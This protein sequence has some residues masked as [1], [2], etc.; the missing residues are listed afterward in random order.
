MP[1]S[2]QLAL[3]FAV[4]VVILGL[5][6]S[7]LRR[8][9]R[10]QHEAKLRLRRVMDTVP[11]LIFAR[12]PA[13]RILLANRTFAAIFGK[14]PK[15]IIGKRHQDLNPSPELHDILLDDLEVMREGRTVQRFAR[16][17]PDPQGRMHYYHTVKVPF[18]YSN[19]HPKGVLCVSMDVT[20]QTEQAE[21]QRKLALAVAQSSEAIFLTDAHGQITYANPAMCALSGY[22]E[23]ELLHQRAHFFREDQEQSEQFRYIRNILEHGQSWQGVIEHH[24]RNGLVYEAW[25]TISPVR[26]DRELL[27]GYVCIQRDVTREKALERQVRQME[28]LESIGILTGGI[29]H[30]FNNILLSILGYAEL[31]R[32]EDEPDTERIK[33]SREITIAASRARDLVAQLLDFSG[34]AERDLTALFVNTLIEEAA[35]L[36]RAILPQTISLTLQPQ[37]TGCIR[38]NAGQILRVLTNL[39]TNA[40]QAMQN[41]GSLTIASAD[42]TIP[43]EQAGEWVEIMVQ[44]TG[45]GIAKDIQDKIFDPFFTTKPLGQ[46]TGLGLSVVHGIVTA[47]DGQLN[48]ESSAHSGTIFRMLFP[49]IKPD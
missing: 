24:R 40:I 22:E 19:D 14:T 25:T 17:L 3:Y 43:G 44:D 2:Q 38:G 13:G 26:D 6:L 49:A 16:A 4:I 20:E 23:A 31:I 41:G 42:I 30:D 36:I 21:Q 18:R 1:D 46:G 48:V 29:A 5:V 34:P 7:Y 27:T 47:H 11:H 15:D 33:H 32:D 45:P 8:I 12:D 28:K 10:R 35:G 39:A 37:A 9:S